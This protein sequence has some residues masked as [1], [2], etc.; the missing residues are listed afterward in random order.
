MVGAQVFEKNIQKYQIY[1]TICGLAS[2]G[3]LCNLFYLSADISFQQLSF[4]ETVS[5]LV[6][7]FFEVPTGACADLLGRKKSIALGC[8]LMGTEFVLIAAGFNYQVFVLAALIGGIGICLESGADDALLYDSLKKLNRQHEFKKYLG[9]SNAMFK[10]S[11]GIAGVVSSYIYGYDQAIIFYV[12]GVVFFFLAGFILTVEETVEQPVQ[13]EQLNMSIRLFTTIKRSC[14]YL[15]SD[16]KLLWML[17]FTGIITATIRAH[18]SIIRP[19]LLENALP[20]ITYLGFVL[21]AA[22]AI[23]SLISWHADKISRQWSENSILIA[24]AAIA[25]VA[26]IS[27]GAISGLT[28]ISFIF[29]I[30]VINAFKSIYLSDYWHRHFTDRERVTLTSVKQACYSFLGILVLVSVGIMTDSMG[31]QQTSLALGAFIIL[32]ASLLM[33][34]KP[35]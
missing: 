22:M 30:T 6:L 28:S 34:C 32:S 33:L 20:S 2:A 25:G 19:S 8:L 15:L 13:S 18:T 29:A 35:K 26:F 7:V 14:I 27:M 12:F 1:V 23:S 24:F 17:L 11:A 10:M 9:Q 3:P 5:L 16:K 4:I 21:A 31:I